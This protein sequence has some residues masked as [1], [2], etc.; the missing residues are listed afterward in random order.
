[1]KQI[2][3]FFWLGLFS[4]GAHSQPVEPVNLTNDEAVLFIKGRNLSSTRMAGGSPML[5]FKEDGTMYGS[6]GGSSDSGTWRIEE[7][8][9]CMAWRKWEY[10]GCGHLQKLGSEIRHLYPSGAVHLVF[11]P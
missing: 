2:T 10:E 9:L 6:N 1:M 7:G 8:K 5:Q 4:A 3:G 11:R